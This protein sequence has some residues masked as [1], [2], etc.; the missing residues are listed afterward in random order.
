MMYR[1]KSKAKLKYLTD[2]LF[3]KLVDTNI[4][5]TPRQKSNIV[6]YSNDLKEDLDRLEKYDKVKDFLKTNPS[7][8]SAILGFDSY[9]DFKHYYSSNYTKDVNEEIFNLVKEVFEHK[10]YK[11]VVK[12]RGTRR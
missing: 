5:L 2:L 11:Y 3:G 12:E 4:D 7:Y 9:E 10:Y 1:I 6:T 8:L